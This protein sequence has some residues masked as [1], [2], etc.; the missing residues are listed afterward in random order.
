MSSLVITQLK[1]IPLVK[2]GDSISSLMMQALHDERIELESGDILGITSKIISKAE[3]RLVTLK[4]IDPSPR[5]DAIA[6][7]T[8]RD[9]RLVEL[10]LS[11]SK[12][13]IRATK[14]ALIVEHHLGFICA[15][16]GVDH[17]NVQGEDFSVSDN[18]DW[19]LL[20][21][22]NPDSSA[23]KI[24]R[25]IFD[26][27]QKNIGIIIIDSHGRPWRQGILGT[28][29]GTSSVPALVDLRGKEDI[30]GYQLRITTVAAADELAGSASLMMG[31]ANEKIP[32]VHI[33]GFPYPLAESS[34]KDV[35]RIKEE[36]LF[37]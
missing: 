10:I 29:I 9:A 2:F 20:L 30:F 25:E 33:R 11:E 37:R 12:E 32:A 6:Q 24:S 36:D 22:V 4:S 31:Q 13:V 18:Q 17:S 8:G 7:K 16:A 14:R 34:L 1:N 21:P 28:M 35:L 19:Y 5:A 23:R 3:G 26:L 15:N 27:T